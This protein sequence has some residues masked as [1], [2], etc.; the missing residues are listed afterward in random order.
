MFDNNLRYSIFTN[1]IV[2]YG[3]NAG[4]ESWTTRNKKKRDKAVKW[5][6]ASKI[7]NIF[8]TLEN[9]SIN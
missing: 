9:R 7:F 1:S 8:C 3:I 4:H 2:V 6:N 5:R